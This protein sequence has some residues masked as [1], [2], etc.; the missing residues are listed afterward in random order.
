MLGQGQWN[1]SFRDGISI[2]LRESAIHASEQSAVKK[3]SGAKSKHHP[4]PQEKAASAPGQVRIIA[5]IWR[6]RCLP[7]ADLAGLRPTANRTRETLFN[8]LQAVIPGSRCLDLFAGSGALGLEAASRGAAQVCLVE[9][10]SG[11]VRQLIEQC[12]KLQAGEQV[13]VYRE[14]A[15]AL[16]AQPSIP[17]APWDVIFVDP[18]WASA[19][20]SEILRLLDA[21][22][23]RGLIRSRA[24]VYVEAGASEA[25]QI[26]EQWEVL[27]KRIFGQAQALLLRMGA[28]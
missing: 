18:P 6:G 7:V 17:G 8:W 13:Q 15:R 3:T 1:Q 26:P 19:W 20:Q 14:D 10:D 16:L 23:Q 11:L 21:A 5:G 9:R 27:R 25:V 2:S 4:S 12:D 28:C 24:W 22:Q